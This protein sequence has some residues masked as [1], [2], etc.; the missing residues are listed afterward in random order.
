MKES[1]MKISTKIASTAKSRGGSALFIFALALLVF[2]LGPLPTGAHEA[3]GHV[4]SYN[5]EEH[6][7]TTTAGDVDRYGPGK[8][9]QLSPA[10]EGTL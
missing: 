1:V 6:P 2:L 10:C 7:Y 4:E 5:V 3:E 9:L 8:R